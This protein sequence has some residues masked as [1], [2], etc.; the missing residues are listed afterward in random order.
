MTFSMH[1]S[2]G[3]THTL[4]LGGP[5]ITDLLELRRAGL[6]A[7]RTLAEGDSVRLY[8]GNEQVA[9]I[10]VEGGKPR[11]LWQVPRPRHG[12]CI[13]CGP[14]SEV[15]E[16]ERHTDFEGTPEWRTPQHYGKGP[17]GGFGCAGAFQHATEV[18]LPEEIAPT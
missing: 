4:T 17:G 13:E 6:R 12:Y 5:E 15:F 1:V 3:T 9:T 8:D 16:L 2:A 18:D 11:E 7:A 14:D 10:H